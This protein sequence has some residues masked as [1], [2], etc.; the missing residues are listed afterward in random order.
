MELLQHTLLLV[1]TISEVKHVYSTFQFSGI[2]RTQ[3][4]FFL[5]CKHEFK[6]Y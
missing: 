4:L 3:I 2:I 1:D 5:R 6:D